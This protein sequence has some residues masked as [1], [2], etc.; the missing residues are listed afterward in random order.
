M[1][2]KALLAILALGLT[3]CTSETAY[4]DCIG[5]D[6]DK[7]P[8]L[9]YEVDTGNVIIGALLVETLI[10]PV[11]IALEETYCPVGNVEPVKP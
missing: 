10:A 3:A 2:K 4:G 1:F 5:L 11:Y 8:S 9:K 6:D 7:N